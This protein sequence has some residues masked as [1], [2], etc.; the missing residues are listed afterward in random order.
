[1]GHGPHHQALTRTTAQAAGGRALLDRLAVAF[2]ASLHLVVYAGLRFPSRAVRVRLLDYAFRRAYAA[3]N[4]G[5]WVLN[6]LLMDSQRYVFELADGSLLPDSPDVFR[7]VD[8]YL[9]AQDLWSDAWGQLTISS[10]GVVELGGNRVLSLL[11]FSGRGEGSGIPFDRACA[12]I[13]EFKRGC[14]VRQTHYW[15]REAALRDLGV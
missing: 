15:D 12:G 4:R 6:T 9:Q 1:M 11:R 8:G 2:P 7:G 5:D 13:L 10:E 3:W 14:V